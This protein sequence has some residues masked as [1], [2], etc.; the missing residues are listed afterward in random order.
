MKLFRIYLAILSII[1]FTGCT[2]GNAEQTLK[3]QMH[4]L[5]NNQQKTLTEIS[6]LQMVVIKNG[7]II[8]EHAEGLARRK[9]G[10]EVPLTS[11]H[12]VRIAS[13]SK[14]V[15]TV[16]FMSLVEE[17]KVD[18]DEDISEYL[19]FKLRNPHFPDRKITARH[20]LSHTSSIRDASSYFMTIEGDFRDF[21]RP[22]TTDTSAEYYENGKHFSS[23]NNQGPGDYF[24]YSN[25]NFGIISGIIENVSG[26]RMDLFVKEKIAVPLGLNISFN[27][28]DLYQ[29]NFSALATLYRRGDGGETWDTEGPWLEQVDG[30]PVGCFY[31]SPKYKRGETP[32]KSILDTYRIGHN[33]TLFSPQGG[34][35]ASAKD[36]AKIMLAILNDGKNSPT[37]IISKTSIAEMIKP[38]WR[39]DDKLKNGHTGG[40]GDLND[41]KANGMM[42]TYGLST[43]IIDLKNWGLTNESKKLYGHLGSAYGL[44]GQFWFDPI[45]KDGFVALITG[46]G[47][48]PDKAEKTIPLLA[49]EEAVLRLGLNAMEQD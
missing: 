27:A 6:G 19:G 16:A 15:L 2:G 46:L 41:P 20:V 48:N 13:I 23:G 47:D 31:G 38:V 39:Y 7:E 33:P 3:Q 32:D 1:I 30:D 43:H 29:N 37:T 49:I 35:R 42:T 45:T 28:C 18:L 36:L 44:Q 11:D 40:E 10:A 24:T 26:Q 17:G 8:F 22:G 25:L 4:A 9:I 21:F 14:Y 12:K 5:V 34:L